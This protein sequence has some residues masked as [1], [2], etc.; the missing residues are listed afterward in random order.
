MKLPGQL[1]AMTVLLQYHFLC[2][3]VVKTVIASSQIQQG[4]ETGHLLMGKWQDPISKEN[5]GWEIFLA[6]PLGGR[7]CHTCTIFLWQRITAILILCGP[8]SPAALLSV[9]PLWL[10]KELHG[11]WQR[12]SNWRG[13]EELWGREKGD[14]AAQRTSSLGKCQRC[15]LSEPCP[16]AWEPL[17]GQQPVSQPP[18]GQLPLLLSQHAL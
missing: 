16:P 10:L 15:F 11:D 3:L 12:L 14:A 2:F 4:K 13:E 8:F 1:R 17:P 6:P 9:H 7:I 18:W 5:A